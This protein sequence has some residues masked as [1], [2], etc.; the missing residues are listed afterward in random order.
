MGREESAGE[1]TLEP[2]SIWTNDEPRLHL[3]AWDG[4]GPPLLL[5]H[6]M[7]ANT[8]WWDECA[9]VLSRSFR[10]V[11]LDLSGHGDSGRR[12]TYTSE[13]WVAD[14]ESARHCLGW[15]KFTL[16]AHSLG[17]RVA[18]EYAKRHGDRL[19]K[20]VAI[21]FLPVANQTKA[22]RFAKR[23]PVPT[24]VYP[25]KDDVLGRFRLQPEGTSLD[26]KAV[27]ALGEHCVRP[28]K[29][30]QW[31]WK[32]DWRAFSYKYDP[33]WPVLEQVKVPALFVRGEHST[34]VD[35]EDFA[36]IGGLVPGSK[37]I[38]IK[39][40]HHHVPLDAPRELA[41]AVADFLA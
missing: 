8:H 11:A 34:V 16:V 23:K 1:L 36:K 39:G 21:D 10:P 12:E 15:P 17:A 5:V 28:T 32:Y 4:D 18:L 2:Q 25:S 31:T 40:A 6:G 24:P 7:G 41:Q 13:G 9:G 33:I 19:D 27:A 14:L 29:D 22:S 20:L 3:A 37:S 26:D 30:G 38:E 35:A